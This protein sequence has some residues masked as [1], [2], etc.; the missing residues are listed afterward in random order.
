MRLRSLLAGAAL[1]GSLGIG[2]IAMMAAPAS[3]AVVVQPGSHNN[4]PLT[5]YGDCG[6]MPQQC[7]GIRNDSSQQNW[8]NSKNCCNQEITFRFAPNKNTPPGTK[9]TWLLETAGPALYTGEALTYDGGTWIVK[10]WVTP[11]DPKATGSLGAGDYFTLFQG[12][13]ELSGP[14]GGPQTAWTQQT[15]TPVTVTNPCPCNTDPCNTHH[16]TLTLESYQGRDNGNP[17]GI[18]LPKP[19]KPVIVKTDPC[20]VL[21]ADPC[22][23]PVL[24]A[25]PCKPV[26]KT[27][28]DQQGQGRGGQ[29]GNNGDPGNQ[30]Q[31]GQGGNP[32]GQGNGGNPGGQGGHGHGGPKLTLA[33]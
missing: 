10:G 19:C 27:Y 12:S 28:S 9:G 7:G 16:G 17:C 20:P 24:N 33:P 5:K 8:D 31:G 23:F 30:G 18:Q 4:C 13:T 11:P 3:A 21:K 1:A 32:G 15:C 2:G 14:F 25:D 26:T 6:Q 29:G 22:K